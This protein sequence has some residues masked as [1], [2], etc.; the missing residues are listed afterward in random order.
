MFDSLRMGR[1]APEYAHMDILGLQHTG[2]TS[3]YPVYGYNGRLPHSHRNVYDAGRADIWLCRGTP[4]NIHDVV[5]E[6]TVPF[7][8]IHG[9]GFGV[10]CV[11]R[12]SPRSRTGHTDY[13]GVHVRTCSLLRTRHSIVS[14]YRERNNCFLYRLYNHYESSGVHTFLCPYKRRSSTSLYRA[15]TSYVHILVYLPGQYASRRRT[16]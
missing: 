4:H 11:H 13:V 14:P 8:H 5:N 2:H 16:L 7:R 15:R 3:S 6:C 1:I 10:F 9:N 12:E